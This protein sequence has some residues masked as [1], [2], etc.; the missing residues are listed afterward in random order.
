MKQHDYELEYDF[1]EASRKGTLAERVFHK[2]RI[3]NTLPLIR[4][5]GLNILDLGCGTGIF[6]E[7]LCKKNHVVGLDVSLWCLQRA[8]EHAIKTK[9]IPKLLIAGS[10]GKLPLKPNRNFDL[11]I[12]TGVLEHLKA[13]FEGILKDINKLLK[14]NGRLVVSVPAKSHFNPLT[15]RVIY[16]LLRKVLSRRGDIDEEGEHKHFTAKELIGMFKGFKPLVVKKY[17]L[18]TELIVLFEKN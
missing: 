8:K 17:A 12:L 18:G 6:F 7:Y 16:D 13:G 1:L 11:I 2:L 15:N 14:A 4:G 3:R 10:I 5:E 9:S